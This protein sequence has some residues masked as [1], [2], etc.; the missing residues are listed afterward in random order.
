MK[1]KFAITTV[2]FLFGFLLQ[3][4]S[5]QDKKNKPENQ[6]REYWFV[7]LTKGPNRNQDSATAA[8]I[9]K[10]HL[11]NITRLY[12]E[13]KLKVAG[14]FGEE[15]DWQGIFIFDCKNKEEVEQLLK[16][17]PAISAGRLNFEIHSW[18]T[19]ATGSFVPG[20]PKSN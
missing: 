2:I 15:G 8:Q 12:Q 7:L 10:E 19:A 1:N 14:P 6:I 11:A 20:K 5:Q 3:S 13:G 17:D 18:W 4:F 9:Q 16:T